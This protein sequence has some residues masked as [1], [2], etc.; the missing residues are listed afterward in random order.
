MSDFSGETFGQDAAPTHFIFD[1]KTGRELDLSQD[2]EV[3]GISAGER[4]R[5]TEACHDFLVGQEATVVGFSDDD[6]V[7]TQL[8]GHTGC[9]WTLVEEVPSFFEKVPPA[10][11]T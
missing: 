10:I 8:D 5:F 7:W 1:Q 9:F 4:V 2:G 3:N 11:E 6:R